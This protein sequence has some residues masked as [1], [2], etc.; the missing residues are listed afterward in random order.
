M[1]A[2]SRRGDTLRSQMGVN[3]TEHLQSANAGNYVKSRGTEN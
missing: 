3:Q 1:H 2:L